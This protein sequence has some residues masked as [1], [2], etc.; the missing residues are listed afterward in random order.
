MYD[1]KDSNQSLVKRIYEVYYALDIDFGCFQ[2]VW[3]MQLILPSWDRRLAK[4]T[5]S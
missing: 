4:L 5:P 3:H 1:H 2:P